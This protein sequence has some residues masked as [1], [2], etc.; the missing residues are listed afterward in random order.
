MSHPKTDFDVFHNA[1][2]YAYN[3]SIIYFSAYSDSI[4][5]VFNSL[6]QRWNFIAVLFI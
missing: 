4:A 3:I 1:W 2:F 6:S 5:P